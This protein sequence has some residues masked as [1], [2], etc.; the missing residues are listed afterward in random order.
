MKIFQIKANKVIC[1][2]VPLKVK[3]NQPLKE[4]AGET[5]ASSLG[6]GEKAHWKLQCFVRAHFLL[7]FAGKTGNNGVVRG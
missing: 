2:V 5:K 1:E 7:N 4:I 3:K 6:T